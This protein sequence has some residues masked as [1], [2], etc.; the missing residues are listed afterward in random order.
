MLLWLAHAN[1]TNQC[2]EAGD[3]I[4][5]LCCCRHVIRLNEQQNWSGARRTHSCIILMNPLKKT[6]QMYMKFTSRWWKG[7]MEGPNISCF[8]KIMV[9]WR[10]W[11]DIICIIA[12]AIVILPIS[13]PSNWIYLNKR[14]L[15][16]LCALAS[17]IS[18]SD[19]RIAQQIFNLH[20]Q[21]NKRN[22]LTGE[23]YIK[24]TSNSA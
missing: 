19:R 1:F 18:Y 24:M 2:K 8:C 14:V 5:D 13:F 17:T 22:Y 3:N 23:N 20:L 12:K 11:L 16:W 10:L 9:L 6:P 4:Q 21:R 7:E 15:R